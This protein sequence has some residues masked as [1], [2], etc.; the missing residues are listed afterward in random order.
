MQPASPSPR[1]AGFSLLASLGVISTTGLSLG[2][3]GQKPVRL[4]SAAQSPSDSSATR[5][6]DGPTDDELKALVLGR[7]R[8]ESNGVRVVENRADGTASMDVTFDFVASL[9]Y[10]DRL[11]I[12]LTWTIREGLLLYT[13][14]SGVP[15]GPFDRIVANYGDFA[16]YQFKTI[17][18]QRMH[19]V[20]A[21]DPTESYVWTRVDGESK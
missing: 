10:G 1:S 8:T 4:Q 3:N 15:K 9:L 14:E 6:P 21:I 12:E 18:P 20:R 16:S 7:W 19:L 2:P 5:S 17:S 13:M 11:K